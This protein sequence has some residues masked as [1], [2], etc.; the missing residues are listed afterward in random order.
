MGYVKIIF[1]K[2][3][4]EEKNHFSDSQRR[5]MEERKITV[6]IP[7]YNRFDCMKYFFENC[8]MKYTGNLFTFEIHDSSEDDRVKEYIDENIGDCPILKYFKY[9]PSIDGNVKTMRALRAVSSDYSYLLRDG[10]IVDFDKLEKLLYQINFTK[11][12]VL[13]FLFKKNNKLSDG[14]TV[15]NDIVKFCHDNFTTLTLFGAS[16]VRNEI[17]NAAL[18]QLDKYLDFCSPFT[19][20]CSI[21]EGLAVIPGICSRLEIPCVQGNPF[22]HTSGW[23]EA[24]REMETFCY[25]YYKSVILLPEIYEPM[26][27]LLKCHNDERKLFSLKNSLRSRA[28]GNI[29]LK[30]VKQYR[31]Y[32]KATVSHP[33]PVYLSLCFPPK[34]LYCFYKR[35]DDRRRAERIKNS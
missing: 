10:L 4:S 32:I 13:S 17:F 6:V 25:A 20:L 24:K 27:K 30:I 33:F 15:Y 35:R 21:F 19:Y 3:Q 28:N 9:D 18:P 29:T 11:F 12:S 5:D 16:V 31:K 2:N 34:A 1:I 26:E 8:F 7:T 22:G 23:M 14:L